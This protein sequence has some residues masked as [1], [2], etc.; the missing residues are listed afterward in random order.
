MPPKLRK[1]LIGFFSVLVIIVLVAGVLGFINV[2][3]S[4]PLTDGE[5]KFNTVKG[6]SAMNVKGVDSQADVYRDQM[7][8]PHIYASNL[9]DLFFAQGYVHA[10]D[11]FWQMDF[12][13]HIGSARLSEM[14]GESQVETDAFLRTLGW[15]QIAETEWENLTPESKAIL[16]AYTEGV[17]AY[18]ADHSGTAL[19]L[20]YGVLKLINPGYVVEP[21][22]PVNS[23]TWGKA[24]AWDL[25]GNIEEEIE[26]SILLKTLT[27]EQVD[28]L[29]PP[30]PS[31]HPVIVPGI[32]DFTNSSNPR[33][34]YTK[35][36]QPVLGL[37]IME[38]IKNN[39]AS[40]DSIL[41]PSGAEIG[42]NNWAVSGA[43]TATG[44]PLI[45]NDPH[46]SI[47]MPSIWY[48]IDLHCKPKS[49]ACPYEMGGFSFAGVPGVII[50]HNDQ[51]AWAFTN[52]GP[53]VMDLY[54]EK[55]NPEN[56]NQYEVNGKWVDMTLREE[57]IKVA[58]GDPVTIMV[59]ATRHGPVVSDTYE[60]LLQTVKTV[61]GATPVKPYT[62]QA[63]IPLP[64]PYVVSL[65]W[66]ALEPG[67][68][69]E[70][71]WGF[72][73]ARNWDEFREAARGFAVPAQNLLYADTAGNIAY[74]MPGNIPIRKNGDGRLPVP[75][76]TDDYEWTGYIPFDELPY[77]VNPPS[78]YIVTANNQVPPND[79]PYLVTTDWDYGFRAARI[80]DMIVN[81]PSPINIAYIQ[82]MQG[83][84]KN[85]N[86]ETIAPLLLQLKVDD[87]KLDEARNVLIGWDY[88]DTMDSQQA[89]FFERYW[90]FLLSDTFN[91]QLP[92]NHAAAGGNR[93]YEVIRKIVNQPD[94]AWWDDV[95]TKDKVETRD[96]IFAKALADSVENLNKYYGS[97]PAKWPMWGDLHTATFRN[98]TLGKSGI[99]P[100]EA[101]FNRGPFPTS[102]GESIVNATGW[103]VGDSFEVNWLP[104]MRMIVDLSNLNNSVTVHTTGQSGHAYSK[105]YIDMADLWRNIQY[106]P[107]WWAEQSIID[108]SEGHLRLV[109]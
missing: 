50:G 89:G 12:W 24:M 29:Y 69:F 90:W 75:G 62:E 23:L 51:I 73:N 6:L 104:S 25:R 7:G 59:R 1:F 102:G 100:I 67:S 34:D 98:Q 82:K 26:R 16:Q 20:E 8:I 103:D 99:A 80:A 54:I 65:R 22:T 3:R 76:W 77:Q 93:W 109:P 74:Q 19:S 33:M 87:P 58:G 49:D 94:S 56:P 35:K 52:V 9:H 60:P 68:V 40:L 15:R 105:H 21:W 44:K 41:G 66:T 61:E 72:D 38:N 42:S 17:N 48:Q 11:R 78:G 32:G 64:D 10:Q 107:M 71:I 84:D 5:I 2:R 57:T 106:Y 108:N 31:D 95:T 85:L 70:A 27:P 96:D 45:A 47:Q 39:F 88:N 86:A 63:G 91:D 36:M 97:D 101:L 79:Y 18:L 53:D 46:L 4:Y 30:Y 92:E 83:D 13:R 43:R 28:E 81:A 55:A 37:S 14:F